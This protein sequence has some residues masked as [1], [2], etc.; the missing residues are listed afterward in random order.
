MVAIVLEVFEMG[1]VSPTLAPFDPTPPVDAQQKPFAISA[2]L[3]FVTRETAVPNTQLAISAVPEIAEDDTHGQTLVGNAM[4]LLMLNGILV[5]FFALLRCEGIGGSGKGEGSNCGCENCGFQN[6]L[7][8]PSNVCPVKLSTLL[9]SRALKTLWQCPPE[10]IWK[11][12][13]SWHSQTEFEW[14]D[15]M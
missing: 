9:V 13:F 3:D 8:V 2:S 5:T 1:A 4:G 15:N 10:P 11:E 7:F 6:H 14:R 12:L